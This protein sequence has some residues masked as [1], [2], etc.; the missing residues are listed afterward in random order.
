ME[1]FPFGELGDGF[2]EDGEPLADERAGRVNGIKVLKLEDD[3]V[4]SRAIRIDNVKKGT[5]AE[6]LL[7]GVKSVR[8][9]TVNSGS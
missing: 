9:I 1:V 6:E 4:T 2:F 7:A 8:G 3:L 5:V